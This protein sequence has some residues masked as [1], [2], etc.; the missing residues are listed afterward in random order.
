MKRDPMQIHFDRVATAAATRHVALEI[1]CQV[2]RLDL[3]DVHAHMARSKGVKVAVST[4]AHS[5]NAFRYIRFGIDQARRG[6]LTAD[7]VINTRPLAGLSKL[8]KRQALQAA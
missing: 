1:N 7:D 6:W 3:N 4:D 2:H 5:V 8:L